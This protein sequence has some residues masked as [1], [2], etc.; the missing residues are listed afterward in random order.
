MEKNVSLRTASG[1]FILVLLTTC[2]IGATFAK[3]TT[4][5]TAADTARVA[6][7][8]V[9]ISVS[10]DSLFKNTYS[11]NA[12]GYEAKAT[13]KSN[14]THV[15]APGTDG[16]G[17]NVSS[18]GV[19]EVS[20]KMT[21][22]LNDTPAMPSLMYTPDAGSATPYEP[23]KFS[24]TSTVGDA[25][26]VIKGDMDLAALIKLFDGDNTI[27]E[28][29]IDTNKY[30]V[31][32]SGDG[33]IDGAEK[34][35]GTNTCPSIQIKWD[36]KY[37]GATGTTLNDELDTILGNSAANVGVSSSD[38]IAIPESITVNGLNYSITKGSINTDASLDWTITATQI[39]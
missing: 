12:T 32:T 38:Q 29:D 14:G 25:T 39:D 18:A 7:W 24:V 36:W 9:T 17:L 21:I 37:E 11:G 23:V 35:G 10:T 3:Y 33:S 19:P 13:V 30:Y 5:G 8:G 20:Y 1:L 27:I 26:T 15:V 6:K 22:K 4:T 31:D 34:N 28:Y 16:E 2:I